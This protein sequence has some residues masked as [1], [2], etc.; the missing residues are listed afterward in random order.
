MRSSWVPLSWVPSSWVSSSWPAWRPNFSTAFC[1]VFT[2]E[3]HTQV[4][5]GTH[6]ALKQGN[7]TAGE[8]RSE[9]LQSYSSSKCRL[10]LNTYIQIWFNE[11]S[12]SS[13]LQLYKNVK[14]YIGLESY[15]NILPKD[16]R[17]FVTQEYLPILL[18]FKPIVTLQ[19]IHLELIVFVNIVIKMKLKMNFTLLLTVIEISVLN[20]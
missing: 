1:I 20:T 19:L 9:L 18:E 14:D 15:L 6:Q 10:K 2:T 17:F 3:K 8:H 11:V 7:S 5:T 12:A 16:L 4:H 13:A